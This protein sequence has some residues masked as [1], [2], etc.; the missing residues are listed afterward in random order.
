MTKPPADS[1]AKLFLAVPFSNF[2]DFAA[3]ENLAILLYGQAIPAPHEGVS[4]GHG[5]WAPGT[6]ASFVASREKHEEKADKTQGQELGESSSRVPAEVPRS[7][8]PGPD[9]TQKL[10]AISGDKQARQTAK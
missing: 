4:M 5:M 10:H 3:C 6:P 2:S 8:D 9:A 1:S 7:S